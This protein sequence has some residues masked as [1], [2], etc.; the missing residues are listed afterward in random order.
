MA[1]P[2]ITV[3]DVFTITGRGTVIAG[4]TTV[5]IEAGDWI[6]CDGKTIQVK[7]VELH[8]TMHPWSVLEREGSMAVGLLVPP[9][10]E[11]AFA[12]GQVWE[13]AEAAT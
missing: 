10:P 11:E 9:E 7:G 2:T 4:P 3:E 6:T 8:P 5:R 1:E 12:V 13:R